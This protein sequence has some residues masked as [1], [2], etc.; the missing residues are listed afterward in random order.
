MTNLYILNGQIIAG[1]FNTKATTLA[2]SENVP[3]PLTDAQAAFYQAN[4]TATVDEIF[5]CALTVLT[6]DQI[7]ALRQARY[8][9]EADHYGLGY[10]YYFETD[11]PTKA[12]DYKSKWLAAKT[13]IQQEL[14]YNN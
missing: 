7:G 4:P 2:E 6:N 12:D 5:N 9:K 3:V 14:P 1:Y 13:K 11:N 8:E 10:L